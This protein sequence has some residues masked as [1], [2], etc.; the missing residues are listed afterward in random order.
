MNLNS[1]KLAFDSTASVAPNKY[2]LA[3][4]AEIKEA[5]MKLK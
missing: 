3:S 1:V 5:L 4:E 2:V